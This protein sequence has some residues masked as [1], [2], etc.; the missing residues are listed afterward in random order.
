M[1]K[2]RLNLNWGL[3]DFKWLG[4]DSRTENLYYSCFVFKFYF[5]VL[6]LQSGCKKATNF[7]YNIFNFV[8]CESVLLSISVE[9]ELG[10]ED[11]T[12]WDDN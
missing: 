11:C 8:H 6:E 9:K 7:C 10:S 12:V 3:R 2:R 5:L 4:L 1:S